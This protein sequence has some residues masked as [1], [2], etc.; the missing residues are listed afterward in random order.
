[1]NAGEESNTGV[2]PAKPQNKTGRK[3]GGGGGGGKAGD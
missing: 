1:M 2:I 3:D